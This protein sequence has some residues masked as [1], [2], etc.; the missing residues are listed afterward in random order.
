MISFAQDTPAFAQRVGLLCR[1]EAGDRVNTRL[2]PG[3][4]P[5]TGGKHAVSAT[6]E[7]KRLLAQDEQGYLVYPA[8]VESVDLA[9]KL[10]L[11]Y[12]HD[13]GEGVV[14]ISHVQPR[15][16]MPWHPKFLK[17]VYTLML[18]RNLGRGRVLEGLE[19]RWGLVSNILHALTQ[20]GRW[21]LD[22]AA[23]EPMHKWYDP[24][25]FD[26]LPREEIMSQR[27]LTADGVA[28]PDARTAEELLAAGLDVRFFGADDGTEGAL[29]GAA[30]SDADLEVDDDVFVRWLERAEFVL[31]GQVV[32]WW[33]AL[34]PPAEE[35]RDEE[36]WKQDAEDTAS[37][38]YAE[39]AR[40]AGGKLTVR[41]L[42]QELLRAGALALAGGEDQGSELE[43]LVERA[44][45][46]FV[47]AASMFGDAATGAV[48]QGAG[49]AATEEADAEAYAQ[50]L[51]YGWPTVHDEPTVPRA[52]GR[53]AKSFPLKFPMGIGDLHDER[54][55][56]VT[57]AEHVQHLFRLPWTWGPHGDR[58]AWALV[59]TV[60]LD[61]ARGKSFAVYRQATRRYGN[62]LN[63]QRVLTK[64]KLRELLGNE[65]QTRALV[66]SIS[67]MGRDVRSTPMQWAYEGKKLTAAVQFLSWRPPWVRAHRGADDVASAFL[68]EGH[69]VND[70][71]GLGRIPTIWWTLNAK[72]NALCEIH[73]LNVRGQLERDAV[74]QYD[75]TLNDVR[76]DFVRSA[77][78][79]ATYMIAL[80]TELSMR[81]V[82]P[83]I[84]PHTAAEPFLT[85]ARFET[86]AG[87]NPHYHGFT[88]GAGGPRLGRI[89]A[90][91]APDGVGDAPPHSSDDDG[92]DPDARGVSDEEPAGDVPVGDE[93][94]DLQEDD[95]EEK[96]LGALDP[97]E[98]QGE[99]AGGQAVAA[100]GSADAASAAGEVE[101][102]PDVD[103]SWARPPKKAKTNK[104][105]EQV[106][107]VG[108]PDVHYER[109]GDT[110]KQSEMERVFAAYFGDLVSEWNP[111][112]GED[113]GARYFWDEDVG[114]H[115]VEVETRDEPERVNAACP[116][117]TRLRYVLDAVF[118]ADKERVDL[119]PVRRLVAA[120]VQSSGRHGLHS[121]GPQ[122]LGK[123]SCARGTPECPTCRYGFPLPHVGRC[124]RRPMRLDRGDKMGAW[125]ARFPRN[126]K[127]CCNY[128]AHELLDNLGNIDWRPCMNLW[129][130]CEYVTKYAT[131]APKAPSVSATSSRPP[132]TRFASTSP[133]TRASTCS[134]SPCKRSSRRP[135]ATGTS[136]SSRPSTSACACRSSSP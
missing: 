35:P 101:P 114:A 81:V 41:L 48:A 98:D 14:D 79:L 126:D 4:A 119:G 107:A 63:G 117:R 19:L 71:F 65:D 124:G 20:L 32:R 46:E 38:L 55:I 15:V 56:P 89:D 97:Y 36:L 11:T 102:V 122:V 16:R 133:T 130:V 49:N 17:G 3:L 135:W 34:R 83:E 6:D 75:D 40:L 100:A 72:Y 92:P 110:Q 30:A 57:R 70:S 73:R 5:G 52:P 62:R 116:E 112:F 64:G 128:E 54:P 42:V 134:A 8:T 113:G 43:D 2:G 82:M 121:T 26:L 123:L 105:R 78:D 50:S 108:F 1:Y 68:P 111:C 53:F 33:V 93:P 118:G 127:L 23:D 67:A 27:A 91:L 59:N 66:G 61:E 47:G 69:R 25:A 88:I 120:L 95:P 39:L 76:F 129:A 24:R 94:P 13:L 106:S 136:A 125:F 28:L 84:V 9:G 74:K 51:A 31:G 7:E 37:A 85:M 18:R 80:R 115:D 90:D 99:E 60:L 77:P 45:E 29:D 12:D 44:L 21:R 10:R 109:N 131:K 22:G 132:S 86:G 96:A 104:L 103:P 58:L 87:G